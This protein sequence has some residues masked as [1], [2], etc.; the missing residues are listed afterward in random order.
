MTGISNLQSL[1]AIPNVPNCLWNIPMNKKVSYQWCVLL[2]CLG[3]MLPLLHLLLILYH[4]WIVLWIL[5]L[6]QLLILNSLALQ[7][8]YLHHLLLLW[9][10]CTWTL[11]KQKGKGRCTKLLMLKTSGWPNIFKRIHLR[12]QLKKIRKFTCV[13]QIQ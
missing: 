7:S 1:I 3:L 6:H 11:V 5:L 13:H 9:L 4:L 12:L 8:N 2:L 10:W